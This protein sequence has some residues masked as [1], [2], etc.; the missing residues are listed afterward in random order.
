MIIP[1]LSEHE[2]FGS[3]SLLQAGVC[4]SDVTWYYNCIIVGSEGNLNPDF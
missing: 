2:R 4:V 3:I 1:R